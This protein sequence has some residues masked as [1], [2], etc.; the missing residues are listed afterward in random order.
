MCCISI[1]YKLVEEFS[2]KHNN[3][4]VSSYK[5]K[6]KNIDGSIFIE[7]RHLL[8]LMTLQEQ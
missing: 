6:F 8:H 4:L 2:L 5:S 1:S 7:K 3:K